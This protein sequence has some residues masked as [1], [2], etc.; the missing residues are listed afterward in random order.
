M[1]KK[2]KQDAVAV[3]VSGA[4]GIRPRQPLPPADSLKAERV[5]LVA[6]PNSERLK[7]ERVQQRLQGMT[8]WRLCPGG[9]SIDRLRQFPN[10]QVA[11]DFAGFLARFAADTGQPIGVE[12]AGKHVTIAVRARQGSGLTETALDFAQTLG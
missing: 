1:S 5:Q 11:A 9:K 8:G 4:R 10:A 3:G 12:L 2:S 6:E 7:A